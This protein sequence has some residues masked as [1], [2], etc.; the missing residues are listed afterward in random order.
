MNERTIAGLFRLGG[1]TGRLLGPYRYSLMDLA[2]RVSAMRDPG[3]VSR[4]TQNYL[5]STFATSEQEARSMALQSIREYG[6]TLAD[7]AWASAAPPHEIRRNVQLVGMKHIDALGAG[8]GGIVAMCHFG[9]WD[10][11]GAI[12][13]TLGLKITTVMNPIGSDT[14]TAVVRSLRERNGMEIYFADD[15]ARGVLRAL[16]R[17]RLVAILCDIPGNHGPMVPVQY[18]G[19]TVRFS[20]APSWF[21]RHTGKPIMP[22]ACWRSGDGYILRAFPPIPVHKH[23][24]DADV[25]GRIAREFT[26][27]IAMCPVQWYP[28]HDVFEREL[29]QGE[30]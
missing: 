4:T 14:M 2:M 7:F 29:S 6:R 18:C 15:A 16:K 5:L 27:L 26:E 21:A 28:F 1:E 22:L 19:G 9:N 8:G 30:G 24:V 23:D 11:A 13:Q 25:M 3:R 17:G 20:S 10:M 12:G